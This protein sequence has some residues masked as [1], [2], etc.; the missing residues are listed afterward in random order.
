VP[1]SLYPLLS[2]QVD[3]HSDVDQYRRVLLCGCRCVELDVWDGDDGQ[4]V[5][6]HGNDG[7][8]W[9][10]KILFHDVLNAINDSAFIHNDLPVILSIENHASETQQVPHSCKNRDVFTGGEAQ[11]DRGA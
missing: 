1:P 8:H 2:L 5:I 6:Y 9:S 10:T 4:P 11:E 3:G 7:I